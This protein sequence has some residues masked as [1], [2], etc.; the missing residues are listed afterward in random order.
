MKKNILYAAFTIALAGT[1]GSLFLSEVLHWTPCVLCWYQRIM[2]Y[3]LVIIFA[4]AIIKDIG[5]LEYI[6]LPMT[7]IG[8]LVALY[9]NLLQYHIISEK[10][11]PCSVGA[12]CITLYHF[13]FNFLTLPLLSFI[14]FTAIAILMIIYRK[15]SHE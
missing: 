5:N 4:A 3:P 2:L 9:H 13:W 8:M 11:A 7:G 14:T 12:S 1:A 10:L 6:V 15:N